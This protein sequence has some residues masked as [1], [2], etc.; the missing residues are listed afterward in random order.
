MGG[1]HGSDRTLPVPLRLELTIH[2]GR[3]WETQGFQ[4]VSRF[5]GIPAISSRPRLYLAR[6]L[7][8]SPSR[9]SPSVCWDPAPRVAPVT[10]SIPSEQISRIKSTTGS[11]FKCFQ[12]WPGRHIKHPLPLHL[13]PA[14]HPG[15][16]T[17]QNLIKGP[18][19]PTSQL[20]P[21]SNKRKAKTAWGKQEREK[22]WWRIGVE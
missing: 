21:T 13:M 10:R 6:S 17:N 7:S 3:H 11:S 5:P 2:F 19:N 1:E 8:F 18:D 14:C 4:M 9:A 16:T 15:G 20:L 22:R 12:P